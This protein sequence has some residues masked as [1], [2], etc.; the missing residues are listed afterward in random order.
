MWH[1]ES[2]DVKSQYRGMAERIKRKH[3][4]DHPGYQYTP[5]KP[6]EKKRRSTARRSHSHENRSSSPQTVSRKAATSSSQLASHNN[7][8]SSF[9]TGTVVPYDASNAYV[10]AAVPSAN[11][12]ISFG[13]AIDAS[14]YSGD[15]A[16]QSFS[17]PSTGTEL[18]SYTDPPSLDNMNNMHLLPEMQAYFD[19]I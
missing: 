15:V 6:S 16:Q 12:D 4:Q 19:F 7:P 13:S 18:N 11:F 5:R 8:A 17:M 2:E 3:A 1:E 10:F 9:E 14:L